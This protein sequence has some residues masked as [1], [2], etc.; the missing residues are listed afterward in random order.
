M[1]SWTSSPHQYL[2]ILTL[3][4]S[5]MTKKRQILDSIFWGNKSMLENEKQ[6]HLQDS[7]RNVKA[8]V[9]FMVSLN[10]QDPRIVNVVAS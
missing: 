8:E 9:Y 4:A 1:Q 3:L 5:D 2:I 10:H 6:R 7:S